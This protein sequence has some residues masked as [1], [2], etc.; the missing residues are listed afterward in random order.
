M[1][2]PDFDATRDAGTDAESDIGA[3]DTNETDADA[4]DGTGTSPDADDD[5]A[6]D[7]PDDDPCD[8]DG[9]GFRAEGPVCGG[10]DCDDTDGRNNP[11]AREGCD[12]VDNNC[13]GVINDGIDCEFYAHT[14]DEVYLIDPFR[15]TATRVVETPATIFDFDTAPDGTLYA[16]AGENLFRFN[17]S[18]DRWDTVGEMGPDIR[19]NGLAID[20]RNVGF[21]TGG[22]DLHRINLDTGAATYVGSMGREG[23]HEFDSSGDCVIDKNDVLY[24]SSRNAE[25]TEDSLVLVDAET[26]DASMIGPTG[27]RGI[28]GLTAAWGYLFGMTSSGELLLIDRGT[29]AAELLH[30]FEVG[31]EE[32]RWYGSASSPGR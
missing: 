4:A 14:A 5:T 18:R 23:D 21:A 16:L 25:R 31:G 12:F 8:Q 11:D 2:D 13:N 29:G 22:N 3:P 28:F 10:T 9:D 6:P 27:Y 15:R 32:L 26:G 1:P 20:S 17:E 24:M 7:V 30:T 19:P